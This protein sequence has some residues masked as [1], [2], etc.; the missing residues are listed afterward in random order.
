M[1]HKQTKFLPIIPTTVST[2]YNLNCFGHMIQRC[3][4]VCTKI[5]QNF[6]LTLVYIVWFGIFFLN[7]ISIFMCYL[8]PKPSFKKIS[9]NAIQPIDCIHFPGEDHRQFCSQISI[10]T[11]LQCPWRPQSLW[12]IARWRMPSIHYARAGTVNGQT[13]SNPSLHRWMPR[14]P[15][16]QVYLHFTPLLVAIT[17]S[18]CP[19]YTKRRLQTTTREVIVCK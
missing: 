7:G 13:S 12:N 3:K 19:N 17:I 4:L 2:I 11:E 14:S 15:V 9:S 16:L 1:K 18:V 5:L 10:I 8:M 6:W